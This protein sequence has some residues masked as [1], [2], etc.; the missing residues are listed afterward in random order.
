VRDLNLPAGVDAARMDRRKTLLQ[1]VDAHFASLEKTDA[2]SAMDSYYQRAYALISS[3]KARE[4]FDMKA[5]PDAAKDQYG[6]NAFGQ[7]MLLARRLVEA[8]AR[9]V[10]V[11]DGG[12]DHHVGIKAGLQGKLPP[13]DQ[14]LAALVNDLSQRGLLSKTLIV[15]VTEFGRTV[16]LNKDAGRDHWPKAFSVVVAGGGTKGGLI[17]GATDTYG[18]EPTKFPTGPE[19]LAATVFTQIGIDP[20]RKLMSPGNRPIDIVRNGTVIREL[21]A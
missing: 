16:R 6:R 8:G 10:T 1:T 21:V 15:M 4:A 3:Q 20:K 18:S 19:D 5:E 17:H 9:F 7:R 13:V 2:L 14:G 12:W 11:V